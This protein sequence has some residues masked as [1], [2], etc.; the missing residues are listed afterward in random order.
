MAYQKVVEM[1]GDN[2]ASLLELAKKWLVDWA[3]DAKKLLHALQNIRKDDLLG[4]V[5]GTHEIKAKPQPEKFALLADLGTITVPDDY[6]HGK[7]LGSLNQKDFYYFNTNATDKNFPNPSRILK[8]GDKLRVRAFKQVSPG[9]TTSVERMEFLAKQ[10]AVHT[11]AQ[12]ASLVYKQKRNE[13]PKGY[14]Y[15]SFDEKDRLWK[16]AVGYHRVPYVRAD[17]DGDFEFSLGNFGHDWRAGI[18]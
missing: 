1:L 2:L 5:D 17:T 9:S 10:K 4:L 12:G 8:P 13:L 7:E 14:W 6:V 18:A 11:G 16:D 15:C 3:V